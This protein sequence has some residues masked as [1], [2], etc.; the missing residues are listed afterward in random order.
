MCGIVGFLG[1]QNHSV[2]QRAVEA[3]TQSLLHR[4]PDD[5]GFHFEDWVGFGFRRLSILDLSA[6]GHQPMQTGDPAI[7]IVF[8]GEIYNFLELR[9]Q[10]R[11]LGHSFISG[12]DTEI[13]L[14][15]YAE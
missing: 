10:L 15:A 8:N 3:M 6:D 11:Q 7:T 1:F 5:S 4:G 14:K 13:L 2:D 12:S 9:E